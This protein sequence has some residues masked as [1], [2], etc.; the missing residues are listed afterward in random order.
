M[1]DESLFLTQVPR[2]TVVLGGY[3]S[4][5]LD[6]VPVWR[7]D[8]SFADHAV[9]ASSHFA[10]GFEVLFRSGVTPAQ[11]QERMS[12]ELAT[13]DCWLGLSYFFWQGDCWPAMLNYTAA[14]TRRLPSAVPEIV[15]MYRDYL[16]D[17]AA[18]V[19]AKRKVL[20]IRNEPLSAFFDDKVQNELVATAETNVDG[21]PVRAYGYLQKPKLAAQK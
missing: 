9:E 14:V 16:R 4:M 7:N 12:G 1:F 19:V 5:V 8:Q 13:G 17:S 11:L 21:K 15:S 20:L 18:G 10:T 6:L 2:G 3:N